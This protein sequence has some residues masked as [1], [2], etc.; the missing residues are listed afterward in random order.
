MKSNRREFVKKSAFTVGSA[1]LTGS[2][3]SPFFYNTSKAAPSDTVNVGL[4]GC[5]SMGFGDL[6]KQLA[7]EDARCIA[8][9]DVDANILDSRYEDVKKN[10]GQNPAKYSDY[11]KMLENKDLDVVIIGTPDHWHCLPMVAACQA[12]KDVY[13][14][15]PMANSIEECNIMVKAAKKY[16]RIVQ[17]GQQQRSGVMWQDI[18]KTIKSGDLGKLRKVEIWANFNYGVGGLMVPDSPV[19]EGVDYDFWLGPAPYRATFNKNRFHGYWRMF[20]DYGGGLMTDWGVHLIDMAL[21]AGDVTDSPK[22]ILSFADNISY[23]NHYR[24]V[25]DTMSVTWPQ[26]DYMITFESTAGTQVGPWGKSYG[27]NFICDNASIVANR[28]GY[29]VIPEFDEAQKVDKVAAYEFTEGRENHD[30]HA[31]NFLDCVKSREQTNCPPEIG[32]QVALYAHMAN[33]AARTGD[34]KLVWDEST[35]RFTN[36][37]DANGLITPEYR[38]PWE[39]PNV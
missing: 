35:N 14:E 36:S 22:T 25:F 18:M 2:L 23:K 10:F 7:F 39:L 20:W 12:G 30:L 32:R 11:R 9:C 28:S 31:R 38:G 15:K 21:W 29:E 1:A 19:P 24:D 26:E 33:I 8:L 13:V 27:L 17:V 6:Q 16:G 3:I 37:K 4:I 34:M 5:R